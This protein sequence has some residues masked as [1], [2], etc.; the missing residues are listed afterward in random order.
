MT[1]S[2]GEYANFNCSLNCT[3]DDVDLRWRLVAPQMDIV[4]ERYIRIKPLTNNK[5]SRKGVTIENES[6][7][8]ES[9]AWL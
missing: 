4:D 8:N 5:W 7:V 3:A 9:T 1:V 6:V 2:V